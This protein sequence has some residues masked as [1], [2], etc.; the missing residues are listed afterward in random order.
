MASDD[1]DYGRSSDEDDVGFGGDYN[2]FAAD[3]DS[4]GPQFFGFDGNG[5][6]NKPRPRD[7]FEYSTPG[8]SA[9]SDDEY[10]AAYAKQTRRSLQRLLDEADAAMYRESA[11]FPPNPAAI[12]ATAAAAPAPHITE[13][14]AWQSSLGCL[15]ARGIAISPPGAAL[16]AHGGAASADSDED[17]GFGRIGNSDDDDDDRTDGRLS[18]SPVAIHEHCALPAALSALSLD[19]TVLGKRIAPVAVTAEAEM[20]GTCEEVFAAHGTCSEGLAA[21]RDDTGDVTTALAAAG[22]AGTAADRGPRK[23]GVQSEEEVTSRLGL[24]PRSPRLAIPEGALQMVLARVWRERIS[25]RLAGLCQ[26]VAER[27]LG[28]MGM[29]VGGRADSLP[30]SDP[31]LQQPWPAACKPPHPSSSDHQLQQRAGAVVAPPPAPPGRSSSYEQNYSSRTDHLPSAALPAG[32]GAAAAR[33]MRSV[34]GGTPF[35]G[36]AGCAGRGPGARSCSGA[37]QARSSSASASSHPPQAGPAVAAQHRESSS[38]GAGGPARHAMPRVTP[39]ARSE[40]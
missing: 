14:Q 31:P 36:G 37:A 7:G 8:G 23:R 26:L 30:A 15:R 3:D 38:A 24:P 40:S 27:L 1:D 28:E 33:N 32:C 25:P 39:C 4:D 2:D 10:D 22:G 6:S 11:G 21:H 18:T 5:G 17:E 12:A 20:A 13:G 35:A 9:A 34:P 16:R 19:L 29:P